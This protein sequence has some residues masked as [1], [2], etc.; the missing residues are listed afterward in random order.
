MIV[1]Y[2]H[3]RVIIFT[4]VFTYQERLWRTGRGG[5][6]L[7]VYKGGYYHAVPQKLPL[8][9]RLQQQVVY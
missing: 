5:V 2:A 1:R 4:I 3:F 6:L 7:K 8:C 9:A